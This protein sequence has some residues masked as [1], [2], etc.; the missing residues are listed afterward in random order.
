MR[1]EYTHLIHENVAPKGGARIVVKSGDKEICSIP[2]SRF[3]GLTPPKEGFMYSFGVVSD[4]H[5]T[6]STSGAYKSDRLEA[7]LRYFSGKDC[8]FVVN[9]GDMTNTGLFGDDKAFNPAQFAEYKRICDLFPALPV[10]NAAGNHE[11]YNGALTGKGASIKPDPALSADTTLPDGTVYPAGTALLT[12]YEHYMGHPLTFEVN[13]GEDVYLFVGQSINTIPMS[14]DDLAWLTGKLTERKGRRCFVFV[15]S[16]LDDSWTAVRD[17]PAQT[18]A[19]KQ[20]EK[21]DGWDVADSGNPCDARNNSIFGYWEQFNPA[22]LTSFL[23]ALRDHGRAILFHGHSHMM[24]EAQEY[25]ENANYSCQNGFPSVHV[26]SLGNPRKLLGTDGSWNDTDGSG[27]PYPAEAYLAEVYG[28]CVLLGG[29]SFVGDEAVPVALG[30]YRIS[31]QG[32]DTP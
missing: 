18:E 7:A 12:V 9:C 20:A 22:K 1:Y 24:L 17:D 6:A 14:D 27:S 28:D 10:Y 26:P 5:I 15:H 32:V 11:H 3:C 25:A 2:A 30:T 21:T 13:R 4:S 19:N 23:N 29:V 31:L 16:F 8:A